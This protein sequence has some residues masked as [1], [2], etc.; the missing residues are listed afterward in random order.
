MEVVTFKAIRLFISMVSEAVVPAPTPSDGVIKQ[1][2]SSEG[3]GELAS[4]ASA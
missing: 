2:Q 4:V 3:C 1:D